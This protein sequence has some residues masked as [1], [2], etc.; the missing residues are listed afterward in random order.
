LGECTEP[1][2]NRDAAPAD[3][4]VSSAVSERIRLHPHEHPVRV[5]FRDR[6]IARTE[7]AVRLEEAGCPPR[8][9]IPRDAVDMACLRAS[10]RRTH[11]PYK[12]DASYYS[13]AV[14]GAVAEDA[15]WSYE[16]PIA[17]MRAIE[18]HLC[19]DAARGVDVE[20]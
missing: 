12:G 10:T 2:S 1:R 18:G 3:G 4:V 7:T 16:D 15:S 9:Y 17:D 6:E 20:G 5:T 13:V 14:D 19:F 8:L 11:C